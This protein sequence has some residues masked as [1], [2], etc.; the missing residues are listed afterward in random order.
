MQRPTFPRVLHL[1]E[2]SIKEQP[3]AGRRPFDGDDIWE[4]VHQLN[5]TQ[6]TQL[7]YRKVLTS[8]QLEKTRVTGDGVNSFQSIQIPFDSIP[9][10]F[11]FNSNSFF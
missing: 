9:I 2:A 3:V 11:L 6:K 7:L 8:H 5:D 10:P 4:R 1:V